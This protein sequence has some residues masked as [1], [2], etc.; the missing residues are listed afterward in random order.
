MWRWTIGLLAMAAVLVHA[1][2]APRTLQMTIG[3]YPPYT[4]LALPHHG[5]L[6]AVVIAAFDRA[7]IHVN[8]VETPNNRAIT[9]VQMGLYDGSFG[10]A[11]TPEREKS[12]YYSDEVMP[13][14]MVFCQQRDKQ[15]HWQT[16]SDLAP[17]R[18]GVTIGDFYS[19]EFQALIDSGRLK[20]DAATSDMI[21]L[22]KLAAGRIDLFPVA[23]ETG[24]YL[25]HSELDKDERT[26]VECPDRAYW[27]VPMHVVLS[28]H[29]ADGAQLISRFNA[30]MAALHQSGDYEKVLDAARKDIFTF[31][32]TPTNH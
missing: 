25:I 8:L 9:G 12:M 29:T 2:D 30:A 7:G 22:H 3:D 21:N 15:Y 16:L 13:L 14:R 20:V 32:A 17:W 4:G 23:V 19:D 1:D 5:I 10:W 11:R 26:R 31:S 28:R 18:V 27:S 24:N 6:T